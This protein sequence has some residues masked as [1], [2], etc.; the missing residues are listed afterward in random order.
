MSSTEEVPVPVSTTETI[1]PLPSEQPASDSTQ[2]AEQS[3]P[4]SSSTCT[5][6]GK[7]E[8]PSNEVVTGSSGE[9]APPQNATTCTE[10]VEEGQ[11]IP[12]KPKVSLTPE[13]ILNYEITYHN[14]QTEL[15][16][17]AVAPERPLALLESV[18]DSLTSEEC[19]FTAEH[20]VYF[21]HTALPAII[22]ILVQRRF[23]ED[24]HFLLVNEF[25][26]RV[27]D[28]AIY[29]MSYD[30][31]PLLEI[32]NKLF[33]DTRP[34]YFHTPYEQ[35]D[36]LYAQLQ[37]QKD[38]SQVLEEFALLESS[39]R[40]SRF[41]VYNINYFV[42][43]GGLD[44]MVA[45]IRHTE[46]KVP[47]S[48]LKLLI[49]LFYR[50]KS[51][52]IPD[53]KKKFYPE[54][55]MVLQM[56]IN[57]SPE[58]LKSVGKKDVEDIVRYMEGLMKEYAGA[59]AYEFCERFCLE[60]ALKCFHSQNLPKR[61]HGL[62]HIEEVIDMTKRKKYSTWND[63]SHHS[64]NY[65][66]RLPPVAK[67]LESS[68]LIEW[69][70]SNKI[71]EDLLSVAS[72]THPELIKR[73]KTILRFLA[74]E[75][76]L[77]EE[78]LDMIWNARNLNHD[79]LV[80]AVYVLLGSILSSL[81]L[82]QL[83]YLLKKIQDIPFAEFTPRIITLISQFQDYTINFTE[84]KLRTMNL[85]WQLVQDDSAAEQPIVD[86]AMEQLMKMTGG[87]S[88]RPHR[89]KLI[90]IFIDKVAKRESVMQC[91]ALLRNIV[92]EQFYDSRDSHMMKNSEST[93]QNIMS[94]L[95]DDLGFI[96]TLMQEFKSYKEAT[97]A[98][99]AELESQ[100]GLRPENLDPRVVALD[101]RYPHI[102]QIN[103][104]LEFLEFS[105]EYTKGRLITTRVEIL[106]DV[107]VVQ[108][109][110]REEIEAFLGWLFRL[111]RTFVK[112]DANTVTSKMA[113]HLFTTRLC[114]MDAVN[115]TPIMFDCF[116][117]YFCCVN[118]QSGALRMANPND[119]RWEVCAFEE[120]IGL[121]T[122]WRIV[123]SVESSVVFQ[124]AMNFLIALHQRIDPTGS[125]HINDIRKR[126]ID[127]CMAQLQEL[128]LRITTTDT[129]FGYQNQVDRIITMLKAFLEES[130]KR[131]QDVAKDSEY[132]AKALA[133]ASPVVVNVLPTPP[134]TC[135]HE[136]PFLAESMGVS[137]ACALVTMERCNWNMNT[138]I[139]WL[140]DDAKKEKMVAEAAVYE[141]TNTDTSEPPPLVEPLQEISPSFF[142]SNNQAY[143]DQLFELLN[144]PNIDAEKVWEILTKLPTNERLLE[145]LRTLEGLT[146]GSGPDWDQLLN[147]QTLYKMLYCLQ[148][149][150]SLMVPSQQP[151]EQEL[152][153]KKEWCRTFYYLSGF[154]HCFDILVLDKLQG[155]E[156]SLAFKSCRALLL[157]IIYYFM[158]G[159]LVDLPGV[160]D[161]T[162]KREQ[163]VISSDTGQRLIKTV[164][165]PHFVRMMIKIIWDTCRDTRRDLSSPIMNESNTAESGARP[166]DSVQIVQYAMSLLV[167]SI[168]TRPDLLTHFY[169]YSDSEA[170]KGLH[171]S[172]EESSR[173]KE[174]GEATGCIEEFIVS[175]LLFHPEPMVRFAISNGL[176]QLCTELQNSIAEKVVQTPPHTFLLSLLLDHIPEEGSTIKTCHEFFVQLNRLIINFYDRA[177]RVLNSDSTSPPTQGSVEAIEERRKQLE[178]LLY[179]LLDRIKRRPM[180]EESENDPPDQ[181]LIGLMDT[182]RV[183]LYF[184][185]KHKETIGAEDGQ[186]MIQELWVNGL[187]PPQPK[188]NKERLKKGKP[189]QWKEENK[190]KTSPSRTS[191][192]HLLLELAHGCQQN[193]HRIIQLLFPQ[194]DHSKLV[195]EKP[196]VKNSSGYVGLRNPGCICYMN[197]LLQQ[198]YMNP[199]FRYGL[200]SA[201][202]ASS[203]LASSSPSPSS[204]S[205][206]PSSSD[207][208]E[209]ENVLLQLQDMFAH[210]Q[211]SQKQFYD[212]SVSFCKAFKDHNGEPVN[213]QLQQDAEE[214]LR[215]LCEKLETSLKHTPYEKLLNN[216]TGASSQVVQCPND[217]SHYSE[218]E[219]PL[220]V[221]SIEIKGKSNL[222][223]AL[224]YYVSGEQVE[225][226]C[227]KCG[228]KTV[229]ALKRA[230]LKKLPNTLIIHLKRF[231]FDYDTMLRAKLSDL[232]EFP[233]EIDMKPYTT[234][235]ILAAEAKAK[236]EKKSEDAANSEEWQSRSG[237]I[238]ALE[239]A[240]APSY[241]QYEL[242]GVLVHSG[243]A[244]AGHYYSFIK[245]RA[246]RTGQWY[247]FDDTSVKP[248]DLRDLQNECFGGEE[249]ITRYTGTWASTFKE[250]RLK[251]A[252]MLFYQRKIPEPE[253]FPVPEPIQRAV[254]ALATGETSLPLPQQSPPT[255][256]QE[257]ALLE[258]GK[259]KE[260]SVAT[261][262]E[263]N[264]YEE[265]T[266]IVP[267]T[268][269]YAEQLACQLSSVIPDNILEEVWRENH[270]ASHHKQLFDKGYLDFMFRTLSFLQVEET[271]VEC[272]NDELLFRTL[273]T[274]THF[275]LEIL[276]HNRDQE[277]YTSFMDALCKIYSKHIPACRWL[278]GQLIDEHK[279]WLRFHLLD[280]LD[281]YARQCFA[282]LLIHI[283]Q[284][285]CPHEYDIMQKEREQRLASIDPSAP[286]PPQGEEPEYT[287]ISQ[288][289]SVRF[290]E[291]LFSIMESTR[292]LWRRFHQYFSVIAAYAEMGHQQRMYMVERGMIGVLVDYYMGEYSP[293]K[294]SAR[295]DRLGDGT[296]S[297]ELKEFMDA[298]AALVRASA[299]GG[300]LKTG[301][302]PPTCFEDDKELAIP[303]VKCRR[304][305]FNKDFYQSLM[306]QGYSLR[307]NSV[308]CQHLAWEDEERSYWLL[309]LLLQILPTESA[310]DHQGHLLYALEAVLTLRDSLSHWR[311][312]LALNWEAE[313]NGLLDLLQRYHQN[314]T[315]ASFFY[316]GVFFLTRF[317]F[318][319]SVATAYLYRTKD[320]WS[321]WL[322]TLLLALSDTAGTTNPVILSMIATS[323][324]KT[325]QTGPEQAEHK[326]KELH[327]KLASFL[328]GDFSPFASPEW[329]PADFDLSH[330]QHQSI[331]FASKQT[332]QQ[333]QQQQQE[334]QQ[335]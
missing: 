125:V 317:I 285:L 30:N 209:V 121:D 260:S 202:P 319:N 219:D 133:V 26:L 44:A 196:T 14:I 166:S 280:C 231:D 145:T 113:H 271:V 29:R 333:Q 170:T 99:L 66:T 143:F 252:Y 244:E 11:L 79:S 151:T 90:D 74:S 331:V 224:E 43:K 102:Y 126:Y 204:S 34:F 189:I 134:P 321:G 316:Q 159:G 45:R 264:G 39:S 150:D 164:D 139:S 9:T 315:H 88:L 60:F 274:A 20:R 288:A 284:A 179:K 156:E 296:Q 111:C 225:W 135:E 329:P 40:S 303:T 25:F 243:N 142:L 294:R 77:S 72:D 12:I 184:N 298:L 235:G 36:I 50:T 183:L 89:Y 275:A 122:L 35:E 19:P 8:D 186:N 116:H 242:V 272:E 297:L 15:D 80:E 309:Q 197:S 262:N 306:K 49:S 144:I 207:K 68:Y 157:K 198:L 311:A 147:P 301:T 108:A 257:V 193:L 266:A 76:S 91:L 270:E 237:D 324:W 84:I 199:I 323:Y 265:S 206:L 171:A 172:K 31:E 248:W 18:I 78:Y 54:L 5:A 178:V 195:L 167:S 215:H 290:M 104:L 286:E 182:C 38:S 21:V 210:L 289:V 216:F 6:S 273:R 69:L 261:N 212:P 277:L 161:Q 332:Q 114:Q 92:L 223:E 100:N 267:S 75:N 117:R 233:M 37:S 258:K 245:D 130:N 132:Q 3:P 58:E 110:F 191:C 279:K 168:V 1:A 128:Q 153:E 214:F 28:L 249:E 217:S 263:T 259:E 190:C 160:Q 129:N 185:P 155:Q 254:I 105:F 226:N 218:R 200:L 322:M 187:F 27:I 181:V 211:H 62:S 47:I 256:R 140:S 4:A 57:L 250:P 295:R 138:A 228:N 291:Y 310:A 318:D 282:K 330:Y 239:P 229:E 287:F 165:F 127:Q 52:L 302:L 33:D 312:A 137:L 174:N 326:C 83:T 307:V 325:L 292:M 327:D 253:E 194:Q 238:D 208:A 32:L 334:Q 188:L 320:H 293:Y 87:Y 86:L 65:I 247:L 251:N 51:F 175:T 169:E 305:L 95:R 81:S 221:I 103:K 56:L 201:K 299:T 180:Q 241:Y 73:C 85:L 119:T 71:I 304:L 328:A 70:R 7:V 123:L 97:L 64:A 276:L 230:S 96:D 16:R 101:G 205:P 46:P 146:E 41:C 269:D 124:H 109:S 314:N 177:N 278:L 93:R 42:N 17:V 255:P 23:K 55:E 67:W 2:Q 232:F 234:D 48:T 107:F 24:D 13:E 268:V 192:F 59:G 213:I 118:S 220:S 61:M 10:V 22:K 158:R 236:Q 203:S 63:E 283:L 176:N 222:Q 53:L 136:A 141:N 82:E 148:I 246:T 106:W 98:R 152:T 154:H 313:S 131:D 173:P 115:M 335:G 240:H 112:V 227:E 281:L 149:I 162:K 120:L 163:L 300:Y 94:R 308:I